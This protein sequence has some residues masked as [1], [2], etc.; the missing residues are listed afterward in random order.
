MLK[1]SCVVHDKSLKDQ[2]KTCNELCESISLCNLR[3][4]Y[5]SFAE[6][7]RAIFKFNLFQFVLESG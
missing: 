2:I 1:I 6:L 5:I 7:A 3:P 4:L